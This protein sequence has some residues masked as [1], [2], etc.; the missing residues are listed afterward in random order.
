MN[1]LPIPEALTTGRAWLNAK[2][3]D[4]ALKP[5]TVL[6]LRPE[7]LMLLSTAATDAGPLSWPGVVQRVERL[8]AE[9]YVQ[10][11]VGNSDV[12]VRTEA[13]AALQVDQ[14]IVLTP[15]LSRLR[16]FDSQTGAMLRALACRASPQT[17]SSCRFIFS[18]R[19]LRLIH[20]SSAVRLTLPS[21]G[22]C[23]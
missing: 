20:S 13:D 12:L 23:Q 16:V 11:R 21:L 7:E 15:E 2:Y 8:G 17:R 3:G 22:I 9:A 14:P 1:F 19:V 6:G 10:I 4:T 5:G 18:Q